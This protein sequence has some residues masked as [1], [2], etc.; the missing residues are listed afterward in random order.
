MQPSGKRALATEGPEALPRPHERVLQQLRRIGAVPGQTDADGKDPWRVRVV[1]GGKRRG[2]T[3]LRS[4]NERV[5]RDRGVA[6][7]GIRE[8]EGKATPGLIPVGPLGF[9][10]GGTRG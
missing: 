8:V 6:G 1:Q 3:R 7:Q 4:A 10:R 9:S 2:V 5:N